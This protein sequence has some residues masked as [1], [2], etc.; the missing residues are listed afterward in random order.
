L[1]SIH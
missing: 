1:K